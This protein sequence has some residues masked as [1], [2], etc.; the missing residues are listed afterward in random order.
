M[1]TLQNLLDTDNKPAP[2]EPGDEFW[3]DP[4]ISTQLLNTH[5]ATDTDQGSYKPKTLRAI[6]RYLPSAM[7][8][9]QSA[10]I[11]DLGCGPGLYC[12]E[13]SGMGYALTG[14]DRSESSLQYAREHAPKARFVRQ[15]YLE[16]FG[17]E[18]FDAAVMIS[19]D[20]GVLR[21]EHRQL[22]LKN[23]HNALKPGGQF[24][25]DMPSPR[26]FADRTAQSAPNWYAAGAGFYR[27]HPHFVLEKHFAYP[28]I[29][30]LCTIISVLDAEIKTYRFWMTFFSPDAIHAELKQNGFR[31]TTV[32]SGLTGNAYADDSTA[33]GVI[34]QKV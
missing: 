1:F 2:Y 13:L 14:I 18:Q 19:Q 28:D 7:R 11:V 24:A 26:A 21:P 22:L 15:S 23:I 25:F 32:L 6:C 10:T 9:Q 30:A 12:E 5:L 29:P 27:P 31:V 20:Y 3:N 16:P 34:C 33:L 17:M 8:L 4:Y